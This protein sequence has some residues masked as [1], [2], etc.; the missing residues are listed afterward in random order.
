MITASSE[1]GFFAAHWDWLVAG[2]GLLALVAGVVVAA[3]A[4]G[5]D[6]EATASDAKRELIGGARA[7]TGVEAVSLVSYEIAAKELQAPAR[8]V[9]LAET[10]GSFMA[11]EKRVFCEQGDDPDHKSCGLPMPADLKVCPLC[12]TKQPEEKKAVLDSDGDGLPDEWEVSIGLNPNDA[13]DADADSDGDGFTN[14]EEYA[15]KTDPVDPASHPDYLDS[16]R[17]VLPL[18][19]TVLPF[20]F[21]KATKIPSGWR[22]YFKDPK[23]KNDYRKMGLLY[24]AVA[25]EEIGNT[26]FVVKGYEQKS[27]KRKIKGGLGME[28]EVDVSEAEI[29]RKAD[30][31]VVR[32]VVGE[33]T[34]QIDTQAKLVYERLETKEFTVVAGDE[35]DLNGSK[36]EVREI[37]ALQ[38]KGA[39]VT[40][41]SLDSGKVRSIDALEQ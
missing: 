3:M 4:C 32:L 33:K 40:L 14:A 34:N 28:K 8:V 12:G 27:A 13:S 10:L 9:E 19:T 31:K 39:R 38:P 37:K 25:G 30:G 15:A 23:K 26:G 21:E 20:Y 6:P 36:Y 18:N 5:E 2:F 41:K 17:L 1:K 35:I 24:S 29:A 16:L 11:S 7:E 22:L